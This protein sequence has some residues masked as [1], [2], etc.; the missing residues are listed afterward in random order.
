MAECPFEVDFDVLQARLDEFVSTVF[1][2]L[3]SEFLILPKGLGFVE[4]ATFEQG[5][6]A[7][8]FQGAMSHC[9]WPGGVTT[10][11]LS[12]PPNACSTIQSSYPAFAIQVKAFSIRQGVSG[13]PFSSS[14]FCNSRSSLATLS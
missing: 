13:V 9:R 7:A 14:A 4:Y 12:V 1:A 11:G 3:E 6:Q 5:Y 2:T 8:G 10:A